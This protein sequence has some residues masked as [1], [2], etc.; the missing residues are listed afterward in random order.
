MREIC[1][2][3]CWLTKEDVYLSEAELRWR[4]HSGKG[5]PRDGNTS[6]EFLRI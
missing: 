1:I 4:E 3:C 6:A 2:E 5:S